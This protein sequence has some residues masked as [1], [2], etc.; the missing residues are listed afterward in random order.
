MTRLTLDA[1]TWL[2]L[3]ALAAAA[4]L[5]GAHAFEKRFEIK[6]GAAA[7]NRRFISRLNFRGRRLREPDKLR[8]V[9]GGGQITDINEVMGNP[10]LLG[11]TWL[12][13]ADVQSAINRH[14]IGGNN[15][16]ANFFRKLKRN[17]GFADGSRPGQE[18]RSG[19]R[20][21]RIKTKTKAFLFLDSTVLILII[22]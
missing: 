4:L 15:F 6:A 7:K 8:G 13:G 11:G 20:I 19:D 21:H 5:G 1:K 22:L 3:G 18:N 2:L 10:F 12:G 9:E 14:G 17:L 16:A